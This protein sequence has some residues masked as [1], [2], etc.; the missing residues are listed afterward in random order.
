MPC[1]GSYVEAVGSAARLYSPY[2]VAFH[3][4]SNSLFLLDSGNDVIRRI[5]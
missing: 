3:F 4:P 5:Q 1:A 2:A